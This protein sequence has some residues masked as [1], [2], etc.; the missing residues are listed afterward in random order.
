MIILIKD[1]QNFYKD[2]III[3]NFKMHSMYEEGFKQVRKHDRALKS[4]DFKKGKKINF[5][6][7]I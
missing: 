2:D 7:F 3:M 5:L 6:L 4:L 1:S